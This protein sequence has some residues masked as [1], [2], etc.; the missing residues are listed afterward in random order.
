MSNP[1]VRIK[2]GELVGSV[3]ET[4]HGPVYRYAGIPYAASPVGAKRFNPP[5]PGP[6]WEGQR[7][8]TAFGPS[9]I[10]VT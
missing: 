6:S 3:E 10:Q 8:A 2:Q 7:D 1:T 4:A 9:P 5:Q